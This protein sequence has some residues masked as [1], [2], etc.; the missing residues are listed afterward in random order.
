[1]PPHPPLFLAG[2][3]GGGKTHLLHAIGN[4]CHER[5]LHVRY[6]SAEEFTNDLINAIRSQNTQA[7]REK[8]RRTDV[9]LLDDIQFI[10]GKESTQEEFFHTFNTLHGQNK[11]IVISSDRPPKALV[12][13]EERL[14]SRVEWGL[15]VD[16]QPPDLETRIA[17][18]RHK[19]ERNGYSVPHEFLERIARRVQSNIRELEGALNRVVAY[20]QLS[21]TPI[22][23]QLVE[24]VLNDFLPNR[25]EVKPEDVLETVAQFYKISRQRLISAE[26]TRE[27][28]LPRQVAMYLLHKEAQCSLPQIGEMLGGRDHTTVLYGCEKIADLLER[29]EQLRRQVTQIREQLYQKPLF[30]IRDRPL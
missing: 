7:F 22:T 24:S 4:V 26:R 17:I 19:A 11:Q 30:P 14:R 1:Q 27:V 25:N 13:L 28:A 10:A 23:P 18:L 16:I 29:D 8:Y 15:T 12:T 5:G 3:G 9:L 2:G 21:G 20:S 6:V